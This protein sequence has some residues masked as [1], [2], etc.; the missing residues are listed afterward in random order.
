MCQ[1]LSI[2]AL[3]F[4]RAL[5]QPNLSGLDH[6]KTARLSA[7]FFVAVFCF[8]FTRNCGAD[9]VPYGST[10]LPILSST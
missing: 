5:S 3:K 7:G 4:K 2:D 8:D 1:R 10:N 9:N 6:H